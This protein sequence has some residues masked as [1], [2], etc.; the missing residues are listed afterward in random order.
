[1]YGYFCI[2]FIDFMLKSKSLTDFSSLFYQII[3]REND[4][5]I[6]TYF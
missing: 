6:L 4:D 3:K 1:M 2:V 5:K